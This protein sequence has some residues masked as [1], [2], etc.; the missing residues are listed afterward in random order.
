MR[1]Y[2]VYHESVEADDRQR[3]EEGDAGKEGDWDALVHCV[4]VLESI[5]PQG[6]VLVVRLDSIESVEAGGE[7]SPHDVSC[8]PA[9][10]DEVVCLVWPG[11]EEVSHY[12]QVVKEVSFRGSESHYS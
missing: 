7:D 9:G 3:R 11:W 4:W 8:D 1:K 12:N 6:E 10:K 5:V 2:A